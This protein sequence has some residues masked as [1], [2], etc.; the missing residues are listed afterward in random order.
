MPVPPACRQC[1]TPFEFVGGAPILLRDTAAVACAIETARASGRA[2]WYEAPQA[3]QFSGPFRHHLR[4]RR[5]YLDDALARHL[6]GAKAASV[7]DLGCGDGSNLGWLAGYA[8]HLFASDYHALRVAR[9]A[10]LGAAET[11]FIAD[12]TDYPAADGS[13]DLIFFNH[14]LEHIPD[15]LQALREARRILAEDG[16]LVIGVPNEGAFFWQLAYRLQPDFLRD[17]DHV[18]FYTAASLSARCREAGLTVR[19]VKRLGYGVPHWT[20]D[21]KLR[22]FKWVDDLFEML[23]R[24]FI[25]SQATSL[26]LIASK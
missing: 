4:R 16:L 20:L 9:A 10:Q 17:S 19:E 12:A 5:R 23:G 24:T 13:F 14:V 26:Y 7:L 8:E 21:G 25:P 3:A 6:R 2:S 15:D 1:G 11:L 22:Q 18:Q